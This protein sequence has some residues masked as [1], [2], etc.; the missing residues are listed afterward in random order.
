MP[1][2]DTSNH[3]RLDNRAT[4]PAS[5]FFN[6]RHRPKFSSRKEARRPSEEAPSRAPSPCSRK[7]LSS[8][9]RWRFRE[10]TPQ[11]EVDE[12]D[13]GDEGDEGDE[14]E[15]HPTSPTPRQCATTISSNLGSPR[16]SPPTDTSVTPGQC[17]MRTNRSL[18]QPGAY[19]SKN[20]SSNG[21]LRTS[22]TLRSADGSSDVTSR[23]NVFAGNSDPRAW[24]G[25]FATIRVLLGA[26]PPS[27]RLKNRAPSKLSS[28]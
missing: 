18:R 27:M 25:P 1:V 6:R 16:N 24:C 21:V 14:E 3:L 19:W 9:S 11:E 28:K 15:E 2:Y 12:V 7:Q 26:P 4:C 17:E 20:L 23:S 8:T 13:E 10:P 5:M 22:F